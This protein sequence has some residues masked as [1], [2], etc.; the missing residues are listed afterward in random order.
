VTRA[1]VQ[2]RREA[3][4]HLLRTAPAARV[5]QVMLAWALGVSQACVSRD[6][7]ALGF[8]PG[9]LRASSQGVAR[10]VAVAGSPPPALR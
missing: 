4:A 5:T 8:C 1:K 10:Q 7:R 9:C 2:A 3:L 6:L